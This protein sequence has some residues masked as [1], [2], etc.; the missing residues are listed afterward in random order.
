MSDPATRGGTRRRARQSRARVLALAASVLLTLGAVALALQDSGTARSRSAGDTAA[1]HHTDVDPDLTATGRPV[2][3]ALPV[4]RFDLEI[5]DPSPSGQ[6]T[7][8]TVR[9]VVWHPTV[10][11]SG[12]YPLVLFAH[13]Y[14]T[15]PETYEQLLIE[16]ASAGFVVAAPESRPT[17]SAILV[18]DVDD[19]GEVIGE[20]E[21][22]ATDFQDQ[23]DDLELVV[24]TLLDR[25]QRP[26]ALRGLIASS[27]KIG[28]VGHSDGGIAAAALGF[29]TDAG[30]P[31]VGADVV[32]SGAYGSFPGE[33]F[34]VGSPTLLAI[35]GDADAVN[36]FSSSAGMY[37]ADGGGPKYLVTILGGGHL[38]P[39]LD[40]DARPALST[41][42]ARFL[43]AY[44]REQRTSWTA[45]LDQSATGAESVWSLVD[46]DS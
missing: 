38:E 28:V 20:H 41:L 11:R 26:D 34:P 7:G 39:L 42:I 43:G 3:P 19:E 13:G 32:I 17:R 46:E 37:A 8:R 9:T 31:R 4:G 40:D 23:R 21:Q 18:P 45:L 2:A 16:V 5:P 6:G 35:H 29:N 30:D 25:T 27:T 24:D 14:G 15:E 10:R 36:P 22:V 12:G 1:P 33:W 44:L